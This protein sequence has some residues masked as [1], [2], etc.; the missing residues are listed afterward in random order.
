[1]SFVVSFSFFARHSRLI[2]PLRFEQSSM[3]LECLTG[4]IVGVVE[5]VCLDMYVGTDGKREAWMNTAEQ[6]KAEA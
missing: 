5:G 3:I 4:L 2:N 6:V 1:M